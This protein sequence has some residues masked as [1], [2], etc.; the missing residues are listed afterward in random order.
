M[1]LIDFHV[2]KIL[3][4]ERSKIYKLYNK[5]LDEVNNEEE[6]FWRNHLLSNGLLQTYEYYDDGGYRIESKVFNIDDGN[7]P[8]YVGYVG[9]R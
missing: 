8:Y 3:Y 9:Q 6:L 1:N 7:K 2:T 5:T 4:E